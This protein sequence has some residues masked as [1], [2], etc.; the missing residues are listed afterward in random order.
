MICKRF[1]LRD[2]RAKFTLPTTFLDEYY[3]LY[4]QAF[5][6]GYR[7]RPSDIKCDIY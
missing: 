3:L 6:S 1:L 4:E 7:V 5:V 2:W